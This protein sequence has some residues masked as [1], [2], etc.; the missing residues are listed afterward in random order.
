ME[1]P[2][3]REGDRSVADHGEGSMMDRPTKSWEESLGDQDIARGT[4]P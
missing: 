4:V 1:T 2:F 3:R